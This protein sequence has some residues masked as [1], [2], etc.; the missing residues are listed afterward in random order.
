MNKSTHINMTTPVSGS[1]PQKQKLAS[2][3][4]CETENLNSLVTIKE[5][6]SVI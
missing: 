1:I 3:T 2:L 5:I 4:Q 6:E